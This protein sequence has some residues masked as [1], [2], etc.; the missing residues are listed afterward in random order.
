M[1]KLTVVANLTLT[2]TVHLP[3]ILVL[4]VIELLLDA[5]TGVI[6][7]QLQPGPWTTLKNKMKK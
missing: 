5:F 2:F 6:D 3:V 4:D 7:A 1:W